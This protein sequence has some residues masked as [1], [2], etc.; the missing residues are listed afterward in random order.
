MKK[1]I[2]EKI[3][4][5]FEQ[6]EQALEFIE[7]K[8]KDGKIL[9]ATDMLIG[10]EIKEI[11]EDGEVMLEDGEYV[12]Q[13][14]F[15]IKVESNLI[16]DIKEPE[17]EVVEE[18]ESEE[19]VEKM[20]N[21]MRT[22]G[23]A[24]YYEGTDLVPGETKLFLD[25]ELTQPAP[26]GH[27]LLEGGLIVMIQDGVLVSVDEVPEKEEE[28][29]EEVNEFENQVLSALETLKNEFE[30]LKSENEKLKERFNKFAA[31]PSEESV[32]TKVD[33][34]TLDKKQLKNERLK[35]FGQK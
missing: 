29:V 17:M 28:V 10:S 31:E 25:E 15:L 5:M 11:T 30:T 1:S 19:V 12:T 6:E 2:I 9:R 16:S 3:K 4:R 18:M 8:T 7:V 23:V 13:E 34:S 27:H 32:K 26:E 24:I 14:G 22:D 21:V 20:A 35:F 33:F